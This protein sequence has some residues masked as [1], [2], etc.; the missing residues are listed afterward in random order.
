MN[1]KTGHLPPFGLR[2]P[3]AIRDWVQKEAEKQDRSMN[4]VIL[5]VLREKMECLE[6][7]KSGNKA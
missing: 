5:A 2:I 1:E 4:Y 7:E 6:N 3:Q